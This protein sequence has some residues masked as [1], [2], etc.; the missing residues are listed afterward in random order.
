[1]LRDSTVELL[2][3]G[4]EGGDSGTR[5]RASWR[6][7]VEKLEVRRKAGEDEKL[8]DEDEEEE[9]GG[10]KGRG[11]CRAELAVEGPVLAATVKFA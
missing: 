3:K 1:M 10:D 6:G 4:I 7:R 5:G 11:G 2:Y 8:E 9:N